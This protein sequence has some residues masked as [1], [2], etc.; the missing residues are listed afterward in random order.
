[1]AVIAL[2]ARVPQLAVGQR[3]ASLKWLALRREGPGAESG[4]F[5]KNA[6]FESYG[7]KQSEEAN[8]QMS[9][10]LP[11]SALRT[12][13]AASDLLSASWYMVSDHEL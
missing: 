2:R 8:M 4:V 11:R 3:V 7:V 5:C 12:L 13:E 9:T 1:M 10:G 6:A